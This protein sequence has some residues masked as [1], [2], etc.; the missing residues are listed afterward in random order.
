M[1]FLKAE[2]VSKVTRDMYHK[3]THF[4]TIWKASDLHT[5][6]CPEQKLTSLLTNP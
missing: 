1:T 2:A 4:Q 3:T 5:A 6:L